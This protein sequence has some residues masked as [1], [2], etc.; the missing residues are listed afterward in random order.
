M[1]SQQESPPKKPYDAW[2]D[3]GQKQSR[4]QQKYVPYTAGEAAADRAIEMMRKRDASV[5]YFLR[6]GDFVK[7]GYSY[8]PKKRIE[9]VQVWSP[10]DCELMGIAAGGPA[11]EKALHKEFS[12]DRHRGE[13]FRLTDRLLAEIQR[14]C[15][16]PTS[17]V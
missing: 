3:P 17:S 15:E 16:P 11:L 1:D 13:W 4:R 12:A 10:H 14:L 7:I 2:K 6:C 9:K 8:D 5:V